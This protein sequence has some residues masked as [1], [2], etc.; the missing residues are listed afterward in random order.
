MKIALPL[1]NSKQNHLFLVPFLMITMF[2]SCE[3]VI[4]ADLSRA[5]PVIVIEGSIS[6]QSETHTIK[7]SKTIDFDQPTKFNGV[8]GAK[9]TVYSSNNQTF[10]F[11][12]SGDGIYRS[13]RFRG[14]AGV[15]YNLEVVTGGKT[16][17]ASSIMPTAVKPDS[18]S[19]KKLSILGNSKVYPAVYYND[20]PRIQNQYRYII[21]IN[22]LLTA[23]EVSEDRFSDGNATS[24]LIIF[25]GDG[26]KSG[27]K[28]DIEI[29]G[30]DRNVFKYYFAISQVEGNGGPPI[31]PS[32]PDTNLDNGAL[33]IFSANSRATY[34]ITLK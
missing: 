25:D 3:K 26:V 19:F 9:V 12:A 4:D 20:P 1:A 15:N 33:G 13:P 8:T 32:N 18:I 17:K 7:V 10:N 27:D 34:T 14:I 2:S 21:K 5:D 24:D 16:Y 29:Q 28:V 23:D 6:D 30:I 11:I 31:A 22:G